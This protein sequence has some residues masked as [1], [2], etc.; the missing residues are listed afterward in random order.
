MTVELHGAGDLDRLRQLVRD[1]R[2]AIQ[3]DRYRVVLLAAQRH[4]GEAA[5]MTREQIADAVGRSRQFVDEWVGRYRRGGIDR[6]HARKQPGNRPSL[7]PEQQAAFKAR[8]LAGPA[9]GTDGG[10][11]TLRGRDAQRILETDFGVPLKLSAVYEWMHRVGLSCL[12]PRPRHRK[13]DEPIMNDWLE[14]APL[15][16]SK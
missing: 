12:K 9:A 13:N 16:S 7:T 2:R 1:E 4:A 15:L 3:R 11:C 14:R 5:E 6:L 10:V 8:L